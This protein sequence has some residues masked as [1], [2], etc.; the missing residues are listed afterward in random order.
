MKLIET[1][2]KRYKSIFFACDKQNK[3]L[4]ETIYN[5]NISS[6]SVY[7]KE[8]NKKDR[9]YKSF[10]ETEWAEKSFFPLPVRCLS[11]ADFTPLAKHLVWLS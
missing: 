4:L 11:M 10:L 5:E 6:I 7:Y 3:S 1:A 8:I 9:L 2:T